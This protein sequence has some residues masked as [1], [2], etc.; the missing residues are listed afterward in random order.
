MKLSIF[1]SIVLSFFNLANAKA[2]VNEEDLGK[3]ELISASESGNLE[4]VRE[5]IEN[6]ANVN[7]ADSYG[8]TPLM[9]ASENGYP[10][11]VETLIN[12]GANV[13]VKDEYH[14]SAL[15]YASANGHIRVVEA[16][17]KH[18]RAYLDWTNEYGESALMIALRRGYTKVVKAL[19]DGGADVNLINYNGQTALAFIEEKN[20]KT[21]EILKAAG[22]KR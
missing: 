22:A 6:G 20:H 10:E 7:L 3:T 9:Y 11:V 5:L 12:G 21:I 8:K 14:E 13:N 18:N 17:I 19:I 16:L 2:F 1:Y 4:D 15:M